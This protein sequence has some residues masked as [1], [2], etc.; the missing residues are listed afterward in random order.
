MERAERGSRRGPVLLAVLGLAAIS[1]ALGGCSGLGRGPNSP[2]M[3]SPATVQVSSASTEELISLD[4]ARDRVDRFDAPR[5]GGGTEELSGDLERGS[6]GG[7]AFA[8][9]NLETSGGGRSFKVDAR[10]GEVVEANWPDRLTPPSADLHLSQDEAES[11][12]GQL[13]EQRFSGFNELSLVERRTAPA[14]N[15]NRLYTFKWAKLAPDSGA[16]LPTSVNLSL[17]ESSGALV[18]YLVQRMPVEVD[19]QPVVLRA[20]AVTTAASLADR[21]GIWDTNKP[22][23]VRLQ[24]IYDDDNRQRLVWAVSFGRR[25]DGPPS[26]RSTV[27]VLLDARSGETLATHG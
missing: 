1:G 15:G 9:F 5:G 8:V 25:P 26:S 3:A 27:Q 13:A 22:S 4:E 11:R 24:V 14:A 16:E 6:F 20:D 10:T 2:E 18:W 7:R 21:S 17:T 19:V 12:A 23:S